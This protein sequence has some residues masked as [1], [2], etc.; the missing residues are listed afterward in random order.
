MPRIVH[1]VTAFRRPSIEPIGV[2]ASVG[3]HLLRLGRT[4]AQSAR[5][6]AIADL[7]GGHDKADRGPLASVA[8]CSICKD[9]QIAMK[10][11]AATD[12]DEQYV[13]SIPL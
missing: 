7:P 10:W 8:A 11:R 9:V 2:I 13:F 6:R 3:H 4:V 5:A 12:E 1:D